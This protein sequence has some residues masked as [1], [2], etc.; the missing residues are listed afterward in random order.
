MAKNEKSTINEADLEA[1]SVEELE[2]VMIPVYETADFEFV[3]FAMAY[4][5][6]E[7]EV[8][9]ARN[10]E[11]VNA[12]DPRKSLKLVFQLAGKDGAN[13]I[14]ELSDLAKVYLNGTALIEPKQLVSARRWLR[15]WMLD[16]QK[17]QGMKA[18]RGSGAV[19]MRR[20]QQARYVQE[21]LS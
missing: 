21:R 13:I 19:A 8:V 11:D 4:K 3:A 18:N 6:P 7:V 12:V 17:L 2:S 15:T 9:N 1:V 16:T 14:S 5:Q 10:V 20:E